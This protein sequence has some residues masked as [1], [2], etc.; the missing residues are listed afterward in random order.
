MADTGYPL[1]DALSSIRNQ[2]WNKRADWEITQIFEYPEYLTGGTLNTIS[3]EV[4]STSSLTQEEFGGP[5]TMF[6]YNI[7]IRITYVAPQMT[8]PEGYAQNLT[9][10]DNIWKYLLQNPEPDSFGTI[11]GVQSVN[12]GTMPDE[13]DTGHVFMAQIDI[14]LTVYKPITES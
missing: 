8:L 11:K 2:L 10:I 13:A 14:T 3:L 12:I 4:L 1:R 5:S 6:G 9:M 7:D